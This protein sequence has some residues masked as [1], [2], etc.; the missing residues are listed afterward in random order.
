MIA[1]WRLFFTPWDPVPAPVR[2]KNDYRKRTRKPFPGAALI[3]WALGILLIFAL[4]GLPTPGAAQT[5]T[6]PATSAATD[7]L[8]GNPEFQSCL[9]DVDALDADAGVTVTAQRHYCI[10]VP[11][12]FAAQSLPIVFGFHGGGGHGGRM[13]NIWEKH[14]EQ[15]MVLVFPSALRT[16]RGIAANPCRAALWRTLNG[17]HPDWED[18]GELDPCLDPL[19]GIETPYGH[20]LAMV[21][22][23]AQDIVDQDIAPQGFYA[24]GFSSGASMV[25]Q[26]FITR[27][28]ARSFDGFAATGIGISEVKTDAVGAAGVGPYQPNTDIRRP[29]I[30]TSGTSDKSYPNWENFIAGVEALVGVSPDCPAGNLA[31]VAEFVA[32]YR[33][34]ET[35]PGL[36]NHTMLNAM[37][38]TTNWFV[39]HNAAAAPAIESLYPDLG[40]GSSFHGNDDATLAVR[41]DYRADPAVAESAAVAAI[42]IVQGRHNWPGN[43]GNAP[44]CTIANCDIDLTEEVLQFWRANAGFVSEWP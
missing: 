16:H 31:T 3:G 5:Y 23:I 11:E 30:L 19:T 4:A 41:Q 14:T 29:I 18:F 26:L 33:L 15:G 1:F 12:V 9:I 25:H 42:T 2:S 39:A 37:E 32:C 24:A 10:H 17:S 40:H 27:G 13:V 34:N 22:T 35:I 7:A 6:C 44:T 36:G 28:S 38:I 21:Q 8:C 43:N 20:D